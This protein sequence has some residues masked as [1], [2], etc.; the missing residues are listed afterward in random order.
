LDNRNFFRR[1]DTLTKHILTVA[2]V[3]RTV[4]LDGHTDEETKKV[5]TKD[6]SKFLQF[7]PE[8]VFVIAQNHNPRFGTL[9]KEILVV[10]YPQEVHTRDR[11]WCLFFAMG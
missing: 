1:E 3:K 11:L 5:A 4:F 10:L 6:R 7:G 8:S 9:G 2:L